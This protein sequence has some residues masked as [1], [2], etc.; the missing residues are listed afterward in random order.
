REQREIAMQRGKLRAQ[1]LGL[2]AEHHVPEVFGEITRSAPDQ[3]NTSVMFGRRLIMK[4]FRR[5]EAGPNPD[6]EIGEFLVRRAFRRVPPLVGSIAYAAPSGEQA[7][8]AMLQEFIP[9]QGNGWD[10]TIEEL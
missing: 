3:S 5:V 2:A 1:N 6:V 4:L 8:L 9:N 7:S 10:V